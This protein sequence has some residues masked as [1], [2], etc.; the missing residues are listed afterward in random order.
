MGQVRCLISES[1]VDKLARSHDGQAIAFGAAVKIDE[2]MGEAVIVS[3][4]SGS[5]PGP[6]KAG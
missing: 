2:I 1:I 5:R 6:A 4:A 3:P